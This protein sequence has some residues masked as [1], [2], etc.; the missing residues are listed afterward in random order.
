MSLPKNLFSTAFRRQRLGFLLTFILALMV[1]LGSLAMAAQAVLVRTSLAWGDDLQGRLTLE[2]PASSDETAAARAARA[3][4]VATMA[5]RRDGVAEARVVD[6]S[7]TAQLLRPWIADAALLSS[8]PL[9]QLVDVRL[10]DGARVEA[11]A[12]RIALQDAAP[13]L[14]VHAHAAWMDSLVGFM[15][16]LGGLA[17]VMLVLTALALMAVVSIV[18]N[19]AMAFQRETVELLHFIGASDPM[20]AAQ[21][22]RQIVVLT[23]RAAVLGLLAASVTVGGLALMLGTLGGLALVQPV[24]W[25]T[26]AAVMAI[27]PVAA[28]VLA[29]VTAR[30]SVMRLLRRML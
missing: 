1:Y 3:Q 5:L 2:I 18:C 30:L 24:S 11:D 6:E 14:Q 9:P 19:A 8:L 21:F 10:K 20:I 27:V 12:L 4:T 15:R 22:Q 28:L 17:A 25:L 16:G 26:V 7:E 29:L 23:F 13:G